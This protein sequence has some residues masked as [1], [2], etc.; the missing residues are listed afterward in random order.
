MK[1]NKLKKIK[2]KN[3]KFNKLTQKDWIEANEISKLG[4]G[5][6]SITYDDLFGEIKLNKSIN[7]GRGFSSS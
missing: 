2:L 3:N 1:K 6:S 7:K 5:L 4:R